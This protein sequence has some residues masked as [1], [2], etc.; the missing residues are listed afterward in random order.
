[1]CSAHKTHVANKYPLAVYNHPAN[2]VGCGNILE[3]VSIE[4]R[5][6]LVTLIPHQTDVSRL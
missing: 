6:K 5:H 1:M 4:K 2:E 3:R